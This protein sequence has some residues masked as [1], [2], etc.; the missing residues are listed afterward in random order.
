MGSI[1][2]ELN[3]LLDSFGPDKSTGDGSGGAGGDLEKS[4]EGAQDDSETA[5]VEDVESRE[6][7]K[8]GHE[9]ATVVEAVEDKSA[10]T[11]EV[12]ASESPSEL[13]Q[14]RTEKEQLLAR[15]N[16]V[17]ARSVEAE[18]V[19]AEKQ[20]VD[21]DF[22]SEEEMTDALQDRTKLNSLLNKV[23]SKAV[24]Q[25]N[26]GIP[27]VVERA[28]ASQVSM[29]MAVQAFYTQNRDL[30]PVRNY[31]GQVAREVQAEHQDWP[32]GQILVDVEQRVRKALTLA[33]QKA[34][35]KSVVDDRKRPAFAKGGGSKVAPSSEQMNSLQ[36]EIAELAI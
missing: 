21:L 12:A 14:L 2:E 18:T 13:E 24:E 28:V 16:E 31:V 32:I 1:Q 20:A 4:V 9:K 26:V 22:V 19:P 5:A 3:D 10:S 25:A 29:A 35:P 11:D 30:L 23:Y 7:D 15:L 27:A 34:D 8:Q 6:A 33:K 36:K 17:S